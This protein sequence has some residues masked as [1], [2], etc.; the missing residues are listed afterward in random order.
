[1]ILDVVVLPRSSGS[2]L[3][4]PERGG[5]TGSIGSVSA[6]TSN[7]HSNNNTHVWGVRVRPFP[8]IGS[9]N[10]TPHTLTNNMTMTMSRRRIP[11][12]AEGVRFAGR[13]HNGIKRHH[14][15]AD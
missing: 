14:R 13:S 10:K 3:I 12:S 11:A 6:H 15:F 5:S 1:M 2:A 4:T 7:F 9:L 8:Q